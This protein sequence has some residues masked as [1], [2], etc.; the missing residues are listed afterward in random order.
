MS[1]YSDMAGDRAS[2]SPEWRLSLIKGGVMESKASNVIQVRHEAEEVVTPCAKGSEILSPRD[3][4][5]YVRSE[6]EGEVLPPEILKHLSACSTCQENWNFLKQTDPVLRKLRRERVKLMIQ[7][8][9]IEEEKQA[10]EDAAGKE[11]AQ[12]L[13]KEQTS[14]S[15]TQCSQW[16]DEFQQ[17]L[18]AANNELVQAVQQEACKLLKEQP[19]EPPEEVGTRISAISARVGAITDKRERWATTMKICALLKEWAR[20]EEQRGKLT[21]QVLDV[22]MD[23]GSDWVDLS[24]LQVGVGVAAAF[25][26][27]LPET[28][29]FGDLLEKS[30]GTIRFHRGRWQQLHR[31]NALNREAKTN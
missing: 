23:P 9:V 17:T 14:M 2:T 21:T 30:G 29:F 7:N 27:S 20:I 18:S 8:V 19:N 4:A 24:S 11:F 25:F 28:L 15:G 31:N 5:A 16:T 10:Q 26:A 6:E 13:V 1:V 3:L 22:L 12:S